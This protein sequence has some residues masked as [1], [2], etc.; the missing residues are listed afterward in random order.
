MPPESRRAGLSIVVLAGDYERVHY[1]LVLA[2]GAAAVGTPVALFFT[3]GAIRALLPDGGWQGLRPGD[4]GTAPADRDASL[5]AKGVAGIEE[6]LEACGAL[7]VAF[8]VCESGLRAEDIAADALR[9]DLP[10]AVG[11]VVGMLADTGDDGRLLMV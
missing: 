2:S 11:G 9:S 10:I 4:S 6:L 7:G 1:A 3:M 8:S 5:R